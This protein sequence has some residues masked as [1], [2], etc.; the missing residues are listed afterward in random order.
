MAPL[1]G[2]PLFG[3]LFE[4][5]LFG[6]TLLE[7]DADRGRTPPGGPRGNVPGAELP[8]EAVGDA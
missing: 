3:S 2:P 8:R 4:P 5:T 7:R 6:S 1:S